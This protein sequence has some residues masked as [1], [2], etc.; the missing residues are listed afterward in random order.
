MQQEQGVAGLGCDAG[1]AADRDVRAAG[2][3]QEVEVDV[4]RRA[5]PA[6]TDGE[7][8]VHLVEVQRVL[9]VVAG[10]AA[11]RL[12]GAGRHVALRLDPG[13]GDLRGLLHPGRQ[14][15]VADQEDVGAEAGAL[16]SGGDL[17]DHSGDRHLSEPGHRARRDDHVVQLQVGVIVQGHVEAERG[18]VLGAE[19]ASNSWRW[20]RV[21]GSTGDGGT[22]AHGVRRD[23]RQGSPQHSAAGLRNEL[24]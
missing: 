16:V 18:G 19:H 8:A 6:Q 15:P 23:F 3:V 24:D 17:G 12:A 20:L 10:G 14:H 4:D 11:D 2:A 21:V 9:A 22:V 1:D 7:L 13:G 5:V